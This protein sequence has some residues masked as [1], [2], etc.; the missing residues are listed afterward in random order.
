VWSGGGQKISK[1]GRTI[2]IALGFDAVW[3]TSR[4]QRGSAYRLKLRY[5]I[6]VKITPRNDLK[7]PSKRR[8]LLPE[9]G[10]FSRIT[11]QILPRHL[12]EIRRRS[13]PLCRRL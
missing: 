10:V 13:L 6:G 5:R 12:A 7:F 4:I 1:I 11:T 9:E 8:G 3:G 2:R